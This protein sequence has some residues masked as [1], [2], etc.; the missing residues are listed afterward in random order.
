M[1]ADMVREIVGCN[2]V[3]M[4]TD[5]STQTGERIIVLTVDTELNKLFF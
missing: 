1:I 3:S 4:H 5:M 2:L